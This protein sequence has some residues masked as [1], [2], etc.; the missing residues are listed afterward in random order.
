MKRFYKFFFNLNMNFQ[1]NQTHPEK[2]NI[3]LRNENN[4]N[5]NDNNWLS[6]YPESFQSLIK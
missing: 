4:N 6:I 1:K 2:K 3:I 5:K